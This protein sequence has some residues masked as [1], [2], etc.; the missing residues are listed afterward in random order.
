[1]AASIAEMNAGTSSVVNASFTR[2]LAKRFFL[3][4][5]PVLSTDHSLTFNCISTAASRPTCSP[6]SFQCPFGTSALIRADC[7][8][9]TPHCSRFMLPGFTPHSD[10]SFLWCH[11]S[12]SRHETDMHKFVDLWPTDSTGTSSRFIFNSD[13]LLDQTKATD[14]AA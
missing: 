14:T 7:S 8:D 12:F 13:Q 5:A 6:R 3:V 11:D 2:V 1:M 9:F 4:S 10:L